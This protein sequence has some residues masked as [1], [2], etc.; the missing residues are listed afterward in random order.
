MER[1]GNKST[2]IIIIC[3]LA[4]FI[5]LQVLPFTFANKM[6]ICRFAQSKNYLN[7]GFAY[8]DINNIKLN[9]TSKKKDLCCNSLPSLS[10]QNNKKPLEKVKDKNPC[11][12][13]KCD[14]NSYSCC[15]QISF[16]FLLYSS[17]YLYSSL[18][19]IFIAFFISFLFFNHGSKYFRPPRIALI[20]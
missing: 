17:T 20:P 12:P 13:D 2:R 11:C 1:R 4:S 3:I 9:V 6:K 14:D 8:P 10:E 16:F 7:S 19:F 18:L 15:N 5:S